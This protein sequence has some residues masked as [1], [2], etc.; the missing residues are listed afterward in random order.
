MA[1]VALHGTKTMRK[2]QNAESVRF[3]TDTESAATMTQ[4]PPAQSAV[5]VRKDLAELR[6]CG[7]AEL[8]NCR[9]QNSS[10]TIGSRPCAESCRS[11][12]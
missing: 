11:A 7:I 2:H 12:N 5:G 9:M 10:N 6:N 8:Q 1:N 3:A 4:G